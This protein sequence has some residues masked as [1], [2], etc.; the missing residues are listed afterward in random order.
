MPLARCGHNS[1]CRILVINDCPIK[2][3]TEN[4]HAVGQ[5]A[6]ESYIRI[7]NRMTDGQRL[8]V[9]GR[10]ACGRGSQLTFARRTPRSA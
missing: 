4:E 7:P 1:L 3:F 9:F 6:P 5:S 10:G 8:T 2:Q